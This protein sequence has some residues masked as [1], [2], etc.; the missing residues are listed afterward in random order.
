MFESHSLKHHIHELPKSV[1][2]EVREKE[3]ERERERE[4][5]RERREREGARKR[6]RETE[7]E[8]ES[9]A[10]AMQT[11]RQGG[12]CRLIAAGQ[13]RDEHRASFCMCFNGGFDCYSFRKLKDRLADTC[14]CQ[15][16]RPSNIKGIGSN[17]TF[18]VSMYMFPKTTILQ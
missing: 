5:E 18:L 4:I 7:G 8:G 16:C 14:S 17:C 6:E 13:D 12:C 3:R 2:P 11:T 15:H 1:T 10:R 9:H